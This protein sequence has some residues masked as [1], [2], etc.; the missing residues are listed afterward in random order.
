MT[1]TVAT[2][3]KLAKIK[4]SQLLANYVRRHALFAIL[5]ALLF[6]SLLQVVFTYLDELNGLS[7]SY[8]WWLALKRVGLL[9]PALM[10]ELIPSSALVGGV[11]GLGLLA[12]N[13]E[14]IVMRAAG[15][16][17]LRI[18]WWVM[19]PASLLVVLALVF[20]QFVLPITNEKARE[21]RNPESRQQLTQISGYWLKD[22]QRIIYV[23]YANDQGQ[24]SHIQTWQLNAQNDI[25][26]HLTAQTGKYQSQQDNWRLNQVKT[27]TLAQDGTV[28][29]QV[30]REISFKLP[31][32]PDIIY[33]LTRPAE[34]LSLTQLWQYQQYMQAQGSQ[35]LEHELTF[36]QKLL[37]P[38]AV[39]SLVL[40][41]SSFV[42]GSL[43]Q[44]SLG[45]RLVVAI[46]FGVSF[47]YVQELVGFMSL[48]LQ[49]S[50]VIFVLF[51]IVLSAVF[52]LW[53][54]QRKH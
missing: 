44:T 22:N 47:H 12:N 2:G 28:S 21:I 1:N 49:A 46:L 7:A 53:L 8:T 35:S 11:V 16:S 20:N 18:V 29:R 5:G 30:N 14:L 41:A 27:L 13:S 6:L 45:L 51:P 43:R 40:V 42:F 17:K 54:L 10:Y 48:S 24:L 4:H 34:D 26:K 39:I 19:Q 25:T 31:I 15:I 37:S 23:D 32:A 36:W 38:L 50:P 33:L 3:L 52:G 9:L